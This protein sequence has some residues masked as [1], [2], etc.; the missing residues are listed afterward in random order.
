MSST[1]DFR[2]KRSKFKRFLWKSEKLMWGEKHRKTATSIAAK[3]Q[4]LVPPRALGRSV[5]NGIN[6][7]SKLG[8]SKLATEN[9]TEMESNRKR[10]PKSLK[11][12]A[13]FSVAHYLQAK[14]QQCPRP[15]PECGW[16]SSPRKALFKAARHSANTEIPSDAIFGSEIP[17]LT[18]GTCSAK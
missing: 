11:I 18:Q 13:L 9:R 3:Y 15:L 8:W 12:P 6:Q 7:L 14:R 4:S 2:T 16:G 5:K 1:F 10:S 17:M